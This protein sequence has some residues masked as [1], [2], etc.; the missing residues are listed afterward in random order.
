MKKL[1]IGIVIALALTAGACGQD[2]TSSD[3]YQ[4]LESENAALEQQLAYTEDEL[5]VARG[6]G[7]GEAVPAEVVAVLDEWWAANERAD[8]SVVDLYTPT[9]YHLFGDRKIPQDQ[10][11]AHLGGG[12]DHEWISEPYLVAAQPEGRYVVT[13]GVRNGASASA[14]TFEIL[15]AP[16]GELEIAQTTWLYV[17]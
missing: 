10:L 5:A 1:M 11:A 2:V 3:E 14:L 15:T 8:G 17:H 12:S 9:G 13:R 4:S 6:V 16:S 7:S